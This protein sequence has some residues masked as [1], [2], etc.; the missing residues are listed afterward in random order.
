MSDLI[1]VEKVA[2]AIQD[3][4]QAARGGSGESRG[5][6]KAPVLL[7]SGRS[8]PLLPGD[9]QCSWILWSKGWI[10]QAGELDRAAVPS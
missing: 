6:S 2:A 9:T 4:S 7:A 3:L 8:M 10:A 1:P 5:G